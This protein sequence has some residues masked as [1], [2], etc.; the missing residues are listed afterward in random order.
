MIELYLKLESSKQT[1]VEQ[2]V[3]EIKSPSVCVSFIGIADSKLI[4]GK[5]TFK[6]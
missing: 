3:F 6:R 1:H 5:M 4:L 2:L